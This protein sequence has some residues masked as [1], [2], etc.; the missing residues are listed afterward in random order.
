MTV[1][2]RPRGGRPTKSKGD[3]RLEKV[4]DAAEDVLKRRG[5]EGLSVRAVAQKVGITIGNLQYYFPTRAKLLDAVFR[6]RAEIFKSE[7]FDSISSI[8]EPRRRFEMLLDFW[9]NSQFQADQALFWHLWAISAHDK[10]ARSTMMSIYD[11][12]VA[13]VAALLREMNSALTAQQAVRRAALVTSM[14]EGSGLF[15]GYGRTPKPALSSLQRDIRA[16]VMELVDRPAPSKTPPRR[17]A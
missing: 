4:L 17:K 5:A 13:Y 14:I 11:E 2:G 15:V 12:L 9:F 3:L 1:A 7:L 8:G 16:E 10:E 6:R